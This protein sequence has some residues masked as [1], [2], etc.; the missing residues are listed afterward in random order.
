M[1]SLEQDQFNV[2]RSLGV[3]KFTPRTEYLDFGVY[4]MVL[5]PRDVTN[6]R[7]EHAF[8]LGVHRVYDVRPST[9]GQL[10]T[11]P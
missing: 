10:R 1:N 9:Q 8:T 4:T 2:A 5:Y 7:A 6:R 3:R 11:K